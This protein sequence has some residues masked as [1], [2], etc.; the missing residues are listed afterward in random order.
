MRC[1]VC[2]RGLGGG[3][4]REAAA[5]QATTGGGLVGRRGAGAGGGLGAPA[6]RDRWER[7]GAGAEEG[8]LRIMKDAALQAPDG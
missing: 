6:G 3:A 8:G 5:T 2:G 4:V 7:T 1:A